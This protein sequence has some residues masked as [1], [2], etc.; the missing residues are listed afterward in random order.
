MVGAVVAMPDQLLSITIPPG[1]GPGQTLMVQAP[2]GQKMQITIPPGLYAGA[3]LQVAVPK[4]SSAPPPPPAP[5]KP[6]VQWD[7]TRLSAAKRA[8][9]PAAA[10]P[11]ADDLSPWGP[12]TDRDRGPDDP[13]A[14][15]R[16]ARGADVGHDPLGDLMQG[17]IW[18]LPPVYPD[19]PQYLRELSAKLKA[20]RWDDHLPPPALAAPIWDDE[21]KMPTIDLLETTSSVPASHGEPRGFRTSGEGRPI[22]STL[23]ALA[24]DATCNAKLRVLQAQV[25][26]LPRP[27]SRAQAEALLR[28]FAIPMRRADALG[29]L[30]E[31]I[32]P[33]DEAWADEIRSG[34][35]TT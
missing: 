1:Y 9:A 31:R 7:R 11:V 30:H 21:M 20:S 34:R 29:I 25:G 16:R 15:L 32:A 27:L 12:T 6:G 4:A 23:N 17:R 22:A 35:A 26:M 2:D 33:A 8:P 28:C 10:P 5:P 19:T 13:L 18:T 24:G 14:G 3:A